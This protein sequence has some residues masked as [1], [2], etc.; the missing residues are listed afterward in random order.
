[1]KFF[2]A[3]AMPFRIETFEHGYTRDCS[4]PQTFTSFVHFDKGIYLI[5]FNPSQDATTLI[6][7]DEYQDLGNDWHLLRNEKVSMV[8]ALRGSGLILGKKIFDGITVFD[9][10]I[11]PKKEKD[12]YKSEYCMFWTKGAKIWDSTWRNFLKT[13]TLGQRITAAN[14]ASKE[15][16]CNSYS[17]AKLNCAT[18]GDIDRCIDIK[19]GWDNNQTFGISERNYVQNMCK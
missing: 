2:I 3:N 11:L 1:M 19:M 18:A 8:Y 15:K 13:H 12:N 16:K 7:F 10:N 6:F 17:L 5:T 14:T 4:N 9:L